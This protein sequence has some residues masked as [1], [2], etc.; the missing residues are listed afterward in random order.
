MQHQYYNKFYNIK[1]SDFAKIYTYENK[2]NLEFII[3]IIF[4]IFVYEFSSE[5]H[6]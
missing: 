3:L 6:V 1:C 5:K 2:Y 4:P